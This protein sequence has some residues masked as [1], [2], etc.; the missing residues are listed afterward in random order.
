MIVVAAPPESVQ[1]F[2]EENDLEPLPVEA[3]E[4]Q[5]LAQTL[6]LAEVLVPPDSGK[7]G[8]T[9]R[10]IGF[11]ARFGLTV[12]GIRRRGEALDGDVADQRLE[13]GD[14]LLIA[15]SWRKIR[16]LEPDPLDLLLLS[17][18]AEIDEVAPTRDRAPVA[19]ATLAGMVALMVLGWIPMVATALIA[20]LV[21]VLSGCLT[22]QRAYSSVDWSS[23]VLVAGLL[24]IADAL[25]QTG[26]LD[27]VANSLLGA[28]GDVAPWVLMSVIFFLTAGLGLVLSNTATALL[29]APLAI[30]L[31]QEMGLAPQPLAVAVVVAASAAFV[32]PVSTPVVTLVVTPGGYRFVDF[33]RVGLPLL[34]V[35][36]IVSLLTIPVFFPW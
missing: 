26:G 3:L 28:L 19:L 4:Q 36:W 22:M 1:A 21:L 24:P 34:L 18:P 16:R 29:M 6:G 17:L 5:R 35:T 27:L 32:T 20:A 11:R 30:R 10:E 9:I 13:V 2:V 25:D 14:T 31:A 7:I 8:R 23:L 12:A 33:V 15:G